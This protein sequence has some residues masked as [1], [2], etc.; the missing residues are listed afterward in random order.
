MW[1][2]VGSIGMASFGATL[3]VRHGLVKVGNPPTAADFC[4]IQDVPP[5]TESGRSLRGYLKR[6]LHNPSVSA[7]DPDDFAVSKPGTQVSY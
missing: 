6:G 2:G 1:L 3:A 4:T 5:S 7:T